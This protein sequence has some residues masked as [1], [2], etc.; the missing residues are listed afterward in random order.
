MSDDVN[1]RDAMTFG[2]LTAWAWRET[3]P[4]HHSRINLIIHLVAVP[5]FVA[6]HIALVVAPVSLSVGLAAAGLGSILL[7]LLLQKRGHALERNAV[8]AFTGPRDFLRRL[9]AE[10]FC[11]FWRFLFSGQWYASFRRDT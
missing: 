7:S 8:H 6:G 11:N 1:P 5:M 2:E 10:Q 9:Y 4:V 3:S